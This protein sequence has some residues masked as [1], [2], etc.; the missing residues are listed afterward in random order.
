[1]IKSLTGR[2][3][4][5]KDPNKIRE[6][7]KFENQKF[8][9]QSVF[10][11][12]YVTQ[13]GKSALHEVSRFC[14]ENLRMENKPTIGGLSFQE[15]WSNSQNVQVADVTD[16]ASDQFVTGVG[17]FSDKD[18]AESEKVFNEMIKGITNTNVNPKV[19]Q[20]VFKL[21]QSAIKPLCDHFKKSDD[22]TKTN[23]DQSVVAAATST[24][25]K[26]KG[27]NACLTMSRLQSIRTALANAKKVH[28][29]MLSLGEEDRENAINLALANPI[30]LYEKGKGKGEETIDEIT[31]MT[32]TDILAKQDE[33]YLKRMDECAQ[34]GSKNDCDES[35]GKE[36][37]FQ[38]V[39]HNAEME[40]NLKRELELARARKIIKDND[41]KKLEEY[42]QENGYLELVEKM[43]SNQ[44][45][46]QQEIEEAIASNFDAK[47]M[48]TIAALQNKVGSR[49]VKDSDSAQEK[50]DKAKGVAGQAKEERARLAQ[51]VLFNNI[52]TSHL[53][54]QDKNG[55]VI[56]RN[57]NA[58]LKEGKGLNGNKK[59][60]T[61]FFQGLQDAADKEDTSKS[62]EASIID[63][64]IIDSIL[65]KKDSTNNSGGGSD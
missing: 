38:K 44:V 26:Y 24:T 19:M 12:L 29:K 4:N 49:Q 16:V 31:S 35:L 27:A 39:L 53:E 36:E 6:Q 42:L 8:V 17:S 55:K 20:D 21:C 13:L 54:L 23:Q 5:E 48:A 47:K 45:P 30:K 9:D 58:W 25:S 56:G 64:G 41:K 7:L 34:D 51:V 62:R 11:E 63:V 28:E 50:A 14:F 59:Y 18:L 46:T 1:M 52:I 10:M 3:P 43:K 57:V 2:D 40:S 37:D 33:N 60:N 61:A 15:Y 65:G 22:V 32:S